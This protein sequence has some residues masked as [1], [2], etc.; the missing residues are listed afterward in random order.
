M[1]FFVCEL[2]VTSLVSNKHEWNNC[3]IDYNSFW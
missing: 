2:A 1:V 3:F